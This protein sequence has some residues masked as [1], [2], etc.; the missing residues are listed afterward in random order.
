MKFL[1]SFAVLTL[2]AVCALAPTPAA[3]IVMPDTNAA[4]MARGL[5]PKSPIFKKRGSR[6]LYAP[7]AKRSNAP[8]CI[9]FN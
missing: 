4:R 5:P 7:P 3:A 8:M 9:A 1:S 2:A 6:T